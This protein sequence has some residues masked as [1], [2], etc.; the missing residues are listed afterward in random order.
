MSDMSSNGNAEYEIPF[1]RIN[2][3]KDYRIIPAF[4]KGEKL[5]KA[6]KKGRKWFRTI[7]Y[8][9]YEYPSL[10]KLMERINHNVHPDAWVDESNWKLEVLR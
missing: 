5:Y 6:Q 8:D 10:E 4:D 9:M 1:V 3:I 2:D 7:W